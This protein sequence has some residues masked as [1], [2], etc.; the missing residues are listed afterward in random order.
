GAWSRR[1]VATGRRSGIIG[2]AAGRLRAT[3]RGRFALARVVR[4]PSTAGPGGPG[5]RLDFSDHT[6]GAIPWLLSAT[7][8]ARGRIS[9]KGFPSRTA[10]P[11]VAGTRTSRWCTRRWAAPPGG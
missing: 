9:A 1:V 3:L 10:G 7:S 4:Y 11:R 2:Q 8:A 6:T 5:R